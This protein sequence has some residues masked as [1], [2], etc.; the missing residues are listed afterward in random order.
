MTGHPYDVQLF[1]WNNAICRKLGIDVDWDIHD[2]VQDVILYWLKS[3]PQLLVVATFYTQM[4][5]SLIAKEI[6]NILM[7][8]N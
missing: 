6:Q 8:K 2:E 3:P 4:L 7:L 5:K 1:F